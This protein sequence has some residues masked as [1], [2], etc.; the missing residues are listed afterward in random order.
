MGWLYTVLFWSLT[1]SFFFFFNFVSNLYIWRR[2][3]DAVL[4][5]HYHL[6]S[7]IFIWCLIFGYTN[8]PPTY[9][10]NVMLLKDA[11]LLNLDFLDDVDSLECWHQFC[12]LYESCLMQTGTFPKFICRRIF[13]ALWF[14]GVWRFFFCFPLQ[15]IHLLFVFVFVCIVGISGNVHIELLDLLYRND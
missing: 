4:Y 7:I 2:L 3:L 8:V 15:E 9:W 11:S 14:S 10:S 1:E 13:C 12:T 6:S 5:I